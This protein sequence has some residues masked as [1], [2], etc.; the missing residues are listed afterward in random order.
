MWE[1]RIALDRHPGLDPGPLTASMSPAGMHRP[2][3]GMTP[4]PKRST[5]IERPFGHRVTL[6]AA[7]RGKD[8]AANVQLFPRAV[9][10][11]GCG[12]LGG[13]GAGVKGGLETP[14]HQTLTGHP[15]LRWTGQAIERDIAEA[16]QSERRSR[17]RFP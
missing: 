7:P 4:K 17:R 9:P 3:A 11:G 2:E 10:C 15:L 6:T 13:F 16:L 8:E 14:T 5:Q 12:P 1:E